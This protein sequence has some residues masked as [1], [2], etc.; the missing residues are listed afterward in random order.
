MGSRFELHQR[1]GIGRIH[2]DLRHTDL[3]PGHLGLR[4]GADKRADSGVG[5][6]CGELAFGERR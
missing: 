2:D 1:I 5:H 3:E 4:T 6:L